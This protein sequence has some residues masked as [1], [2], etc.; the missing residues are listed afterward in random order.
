MKKGYK[1]IKILRFICLSCV[2]V[3]GLITIV[4]SGGGGGG[5]DGSAPP[6]AEITGWCTENIDES[7]WTK[8][9]YQPGGTA[10]F[11]IWVVAS[12]PNGIGDITYVEVTNPEGIYWILRDSS[13]GEDQYD[14]AGGFFGGWGRY[15]DEPHK[16]L[17]GQYSVLV[18]DRAGYEATDS[19][20]FSGPGSISGNGFI[21][22]EDYTG[23][24]VEGIEMLKRASVTDTTK[25]L[26]DI[27][28]KFQVDDDRVYNGFVWFYDESAEFITWSDYFKNTI[29]SGAGIYNDGATNTLQIQSSDLELGSYIWDDIK[30]FHV[31]LTDGAQYSL[32]EEKWDHRSISQYQ[33]T[34]KL[35]YT[36][37]YDTPGFAY[38]VYVSGS[39]AYVADTNS[40]LQI[41][42]VSN[43]SN[44]TLAG[45]YD[46][47]AFGVCIS[48][49]YAYVGGSGL[50]IIDVSDPSNPTLA[51]SYWIPGSTYSVYISGSYAYVAGGTSGLQ[52][53]DV[54]D[55]SNP[56]LAGSYDTPDQ[57]RGVYI[58]GSYAFVADTSSG[59]Q[60]INVSTPSNPTLAGSYDTP[61]FTYGVYV[62]GSYAFVASGTSG[63]QIIDVSDP[64]N[65]TL[66][67]SYD[68]PG[69]ARG[70]YIS[71]SYAYVA[72]GTS[73][74]L[75]LIDVSDPSNPT[76]ADFYGTLI[77][78]YG[79]YVS[80]SYVFVADGPSGLQIL[81]VLDS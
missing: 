51:G 58:S 77:I 19:I 29:N 27:T 1:I 10:Y 22:S 50:Q 47:N 37:S 31:V 21:Y 40:G 2:F 63:L 23:S 72:D 41:I 79:V 20:N 59:L 28:I 61:G 76:L 8:W 81:R 71:G 16:V 38:G 17:L 67:G 5:G 68:T 36:G 25:G 24:T 75:E 44:P 35:S 13:T 57:A 53:I 15:Y 14:P 73:S 3:F 30:G 55:P 80:G 32:E 12:D 7:F 60:I 74:L 62:S 43:P 52:I 34:Y 11:D 66:A 70:V 78:P 33:T 45:S 4:G 26:I 54:S 49:S 42:N 46:T 56:T 48:G 6:T 69:E 18:R 65:P 39:Y 64:S 9:G